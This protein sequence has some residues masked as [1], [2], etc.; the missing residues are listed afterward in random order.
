MQPRVQ[1][2]VRLKRLVWLLSVL[3]V[4]VVVA[5][6]LQ[7]RR[8]G[9][10]VARLEA[11][12]V[13]GAAALAAA[14]RE[15]ADARQAAAAAQRALRTAW[16]VTR[17]KESASTL[18]AVSGAPRRGCVSA[19]YTSAEAHAPIATSTIAA[20]RKA[21]ST[22]DIETLDF[23]RTPEETQP[24]GVIRREGLCYDVS[25][26]MIKCGSVSTCLEEEIAWISD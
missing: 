10:D 16:L 8:L 24:A 11:E 7:M 20:R 23:M 13:P 25:H 2:Q 1:S 12:A 15:A 17:T 4:A 3:L 9:T 22:H 21:L 5:G 26:P 18:L 6:G 19:A 14:R